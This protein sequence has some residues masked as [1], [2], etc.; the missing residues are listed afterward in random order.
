MELIGYLIF[1]FSGLVIGYFLDYNRLDN[2]AKK[3]QEKINEQV[4]KLRNSRP[5]R[6]TTIELKEE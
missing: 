2:V 3:A 1:F 6:I 5:N 4:K